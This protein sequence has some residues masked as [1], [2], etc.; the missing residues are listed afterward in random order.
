MMMSECG[1]MNFFCLS[2]AKQAEIPLQK[3]WSVG[4][5]TSHTHSHAHFPLRE[6][7]SPLALW[8]VICAHQLHRS[9]NGSQQRKRSGA[10]ALHR[11]AA[12]ISNHGRLLYLAIYEGVA[13]LSWMC[14]EPISIQVWG[15]HTFPT[16]F[17]PSVP[18]TSSLFSLVQPSKW[19]ILS[20]CLSRQQQRQHAR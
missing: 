12:S 10:A 20:L 7:G 14:L 9:L 16:V 4:S 8:L 2:A 18:T 15:L 1:E 5:V 17:C 11:G 19:L 6:W 3:R 13:H